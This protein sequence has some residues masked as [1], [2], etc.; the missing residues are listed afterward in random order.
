MKKT[1][2][3]TRCDIPL[4][5]RSYCEKLIFDKEMRP[6]CRK[7]ENPIYQY[8]LCELWHGGFKKAPSSFLPSKDFVLKY[9]NKKPDC[10]KNSG[11]DLDTILGLTGRH[12]LY[13]I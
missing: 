3:I 2:K 1:K 9:I 4:I 11:K 6:Y 10:Y 7:K 5:K 8:S 12:S 13:P